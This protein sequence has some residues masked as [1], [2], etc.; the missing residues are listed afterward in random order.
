MATCAT[1]NPRSRACRGQALE[2]M[3]QRWLG[4]LAGCSLLVCFNAGAAP[5]EEPSVEAG[6]EVFMRLCASC[7][8]AGAKGDG[9]MTEVLKVAPADLTAIAARNNGVFDSLKVMALIDGRE[10]VRPHGTLA[11]PVW[12]ERL[13]AEAVTQVERDIRL[14]ARLLSLTMYLKSIQKPASAPPKK[15]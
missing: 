10:H 6:R 4:V 9:V 14:R 8:G 2:K 12:G 11:M 7:H 3:M 15:P 5:E 13:G 1:L